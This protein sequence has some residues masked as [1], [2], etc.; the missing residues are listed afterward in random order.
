MTHASARTID[1][2]AAKARFLL[3]DF[4]GPVCSIFA[5]MPASMIADE[6]RRLLENAGA[7]VTKP[8]QETDDPLE[9]LRLTQRFA[10]ELVLQ[11]EAKLRAREVDAASSARPTPF[12]SDLLDACARTHR[13][14]AIVSNNS[15]AAV[16]RYLSTHN[17][18]FAFAAIIGRED[19][20]PSLMKPSPHLVE[21]A[22]AALD[23]DP[24]SCLMVGDSPSDVQAARSAGVATVGFANKP[25]KA[26]ALVA[27]GANS[28]I[29]DLSELA[30]ALASTPV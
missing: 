19:A 26:E 25:G 15:R 7:G 5:S 1:A 21:H 23:A 28:S 18:H 8:M 16:L 3:L 24:G 30:T 4:D 20:D 12:V 13:P 2:L 9:L 10:P 27:A 29:T 22:I 11:V 14:V 6:L 17:I